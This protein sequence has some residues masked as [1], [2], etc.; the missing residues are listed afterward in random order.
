MVREFGNIMWKMSCNNFHGQNS[1]HSKINFWQKCQKII[2]IPKIYV[3]IYFTH[4]NVF[5]YNSNNDTG[6][7]WDTVVVSYMEKF[8]F[9]LCT[10]WQ[11]QANIIVN[12]QK[13][14]VPC[15]KRCPLIFKIS[16]IQKLYLY[17]QNSRNL[18]SFQ[19]LFLQS[20]CR[21]A[22]R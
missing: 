11:F 22:I 9:K 8:L 5:A 21:F 17:D 16:S 18:F 2:S 12:G 3:I 15:Q 10:K 7:K 6:R 1:G 14:F 4:I 19:I 13:E 20:Y